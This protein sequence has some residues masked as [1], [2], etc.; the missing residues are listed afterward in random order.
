MNGWRRVGALVLVTLSMSA[1]VRGGRADTD[2]SIAGRIVDGMTQAPLAGATVK[3]VDQSPDA[4]D[5][6]P[7]V[8]TGADG[9][10]EFASVRPGTYA[11][12]AAKPGYPVGAF[13]VRRS[14]GQEASFR[15]LAGARVD[16]LS[17][18]LFR[19]AVISGT[20]TDSQGDPVPGRTVSFLRRIPGTD[21]FPR[22]PE[23]DTDRGAW[24]PASRAT[25]DDRGHYLAQLPAGEFIVLLQI[26]RSAYQPNLLHDSQADALGTSAPVPT[27]YPGVAAY[28]SAVPIQLA[29]G[30][31]R[32]GVSFRPQLAPTGSVKGQVQGSDLTNEW[33]TVELRSTAM[34]YRGGMEAYRGN[35]S[36]G[37]FA[38]NGIPA[39]D[40]V[41]EISYNRSVPTASA[42]KKVQAMRATMPIVVRGGEVTDVSPQLRPQAVVSG[43]VIAE[44]VPA[45]DRGKL[46]VW[47]EP[48]DRSAGCGIA[49][50]GGQKVE[51]GRFSVAAPRPGPYRVCA[52]APSVPMFGLALAGA[53]DATDAPLE[54]GDADVTGV[55]ISFGACA[56]GL[57]G[58]VRDERG[59][60][61]REGWVIAFPI[62]R[63]LWAQAP[64]AGPRFAAARVSLDGTYRIAG[65]AEGEYFVASVNDEVMAAWP[66]KTLLEGMAVRAGRVTVP[67]D[68]AASL[69]LTIGR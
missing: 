34:A 45:I 8:L 27:F 49:R 7:N 26:D 23:S 4:S 19:R 18:A 55:V 14:S 48:A 6:V 3:L 47:L 69:D 63:R 46:S 12:K 32:S 40:Y 50:W 56:G 59:S 41:L 35:A 28:E 30:E 24:S 51:A 5:D 61:A 17:I 25:T 57:A 38:F 52:L 43:T 62:D 36:G 33:M 21:I 44:S 64:I 42:P 16:G 29:P 54:I 15:L 53:Q 20:I 65:L 10:F 11:V 2:G 1:P 31:E 66:S 67:R 13:G 37:A 58:M 68:R 22:D 39:G 60:A 9:R